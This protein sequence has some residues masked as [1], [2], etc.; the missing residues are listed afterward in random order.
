[1]RAYDEINQFEEHLKDGGAVVVKFWLQ[2]SK[3][4]QLRAGS[5]REKISFKR[6]KI[7]DED[8]RNAKW[9]AYE[10]AICDMVDRRAPRSRH[11]RS[12]KPRT[13]TTRASRS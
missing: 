6:F 7:T 2:I 10:K 1:M 11:G 13:R 3:E 4:E 9:D 8:W 5:A 12:W